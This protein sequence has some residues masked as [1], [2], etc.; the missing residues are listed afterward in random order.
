MRCGIVKA[1]R[2]RLNVEF[3]VGA[4]HLELFEVRVAVEN[5]LVIGNSIVLDPN[6]GVVEAVGKAADVGFPVADEKIK[7][8]GT[9]S[10]REI[11]RIRRGLGK[12]WSDEYYADHESQQKRELDGIHG[13]SH[14]SQDAYLGRA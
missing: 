6:I 3:L 5:L 1:K 8:V 10:L 4:G 14:P 9:V 12:T 13:E 7:V 2:L 11:C